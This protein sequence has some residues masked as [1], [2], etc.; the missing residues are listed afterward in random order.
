MLLGLLMLSF[1]GCAMCSRSLDDDYAAHGGV[2]ERE[3]PSH[4]RVGSA[5]TGTKSA[6]PQEQETILDAAP[7]DEPYYEAAPSLGPAIRR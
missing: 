6:V 3:D 5:F 2:W 1:S 7:Q 4:G